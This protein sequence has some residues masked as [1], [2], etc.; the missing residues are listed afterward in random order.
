MSVRLVTCPAQRCRVLSSMA[1]VL[2]F[3]LPAMQLLRYRAVPVRLV[4]PKA[5]WERTSSLNSHT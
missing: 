1:R 4:W 5:S 2:V 3:R